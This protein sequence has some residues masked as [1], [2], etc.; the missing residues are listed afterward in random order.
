MADILSPEKKAE[1]SKETQGKKLS[2]MEK[3]G[4]LREDPDP[5]RVWTRITKVPDWLYY[6]EVTIYWWFGSCYP[7]KITKASFVWIANFVALIAHVAFACVSVWGATR[8]GKTMATPLIKVY[9]T[10][11]NWKPESSSPLVPLY[12][13]AGGLYL[14]HMTLWF[15]LMSASAHFLVCL[16]NWKQA[17]AWD[18]T[19][20]QPNP[21]WSRISYW[22][23]WYFVYL[24]ECRNPLR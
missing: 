22:T 12:E 20:N 24:H 5:N 19:T 7:R 13:E 21:E 9:L 4:L 16:C 1:R 11:L 3:A 2:A 8:E 10:K 15:F 17:F 6:E 14:A 18:N 23:G